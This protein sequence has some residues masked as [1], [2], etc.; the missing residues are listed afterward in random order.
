[1]QETWP[2]L[3]PRNSDDLWTLVSDA[4]DKLLC[5]IVTFDHRVHDATNEISGRSTG[6]LDFLLKRPFSENSP[7]QG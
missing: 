6:I 3:P 7:F 1:M 4:Q 2:V 5:L